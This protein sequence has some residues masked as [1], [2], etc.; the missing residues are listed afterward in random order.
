MI[1]TLTTEIDIA[2]TPQRV[3]QVLSDLT[4]HREWNPFIVQATGRARGR[5]PPDAAHAARGRQA[6]P[7]IGPMP[8]TARRA[9]R[10]VV[11][12]LLTHARRPRAARGSPQRARP[13]SPRS[14][15]GPRKHR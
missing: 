12:E 6:R 10:G 2:A 3:W 7:P 4:A 5:G 9:R 15:G 14:S 13:A 11:R 8:L 1:K